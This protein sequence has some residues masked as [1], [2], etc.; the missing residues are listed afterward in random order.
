MVIGKTGLLAT[1]IGLILVVVALAVYVVHPAQIFGNPLFMGPEGR[2][3][4][5]KTPSGSPTSDIPGA[6]DDSQLS[7][8]SPSAPDQAAPSS[9]DI[10]PGG[11]SPQAAGPGG[12]SGGSS[13]GSSGGTGDS[14]SDGGGA[15]DGGSTG[16]GG[17]TESGIPVMT[18]IPSRSV[19]QTELLVFT[20]SATDPT[21]MTLTYSANNVPVNASFDPATHV[22][23]WVPLTTQHGWYLVNFSVTNGVHSTSGDARI[24]VYNLGNRPPVWTITPEQEVN[25]TEL[26]SFQVSATD[27]DGD[28]IT[29]SASSLPM[30][31]TFDP[32]TQVFTWTPGL[33]QEGEYNVTFTASDGMLKSD[34]VVEI[35]VESEG[36][37]PVPEFPM[38]GVPVAILAGA[39]LMISIVR[40]K[41]QD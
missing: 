29:Y 28:P 12:A 27:P 32:S 33:G 7:P 1:K 25:E 15:S 36:P 30:N 26:L 9:S 39:A 34:M 4:Q 35:D 31:A 18:P 37:T 40:A 21:G 17:G 23:S 38:P 8:T 11:S 2:S 3:S 5:D 19:N 13:R 14:G 10:P 41:K 24:Y 16:G 22:F 20:V 6:G